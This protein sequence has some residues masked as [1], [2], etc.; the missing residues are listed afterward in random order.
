MDINVVSLLILDRKNK[1]LLLKK[2]DD[3]KWGLPGGHLTTGETPKQGL[4]REIKEELGI[5][6]K[7]KNYHFLKKYMKGKKELN[8]FYLK[9]NIDSNDIKLSEEHSEFDFFSYKQIM[10]LRDKSISSNLDFILD[11][12]NNN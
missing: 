10:D 6:I 8:I 1:F 12:L 9:D 4:V 11:Y 5:N 7:S 2:T 3:G